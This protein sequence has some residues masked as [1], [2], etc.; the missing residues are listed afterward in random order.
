MEGK[1][2]PGI[3]QVTE[4]DTAALGNKT[5]VAYENLHKKINK[6][7]QDA[8]GNSLAKSDYGQTV[9]NKVSTS[10]SARSGIRANEAVNV[11]VVNIFVQT[12]KYDETSVSEIITK[13][14]GD[15]ASGIENYSKQDLCEYRGCKKNA[16]DDCSDGLQCECKDDLERPN[17]QVPFCLALVSNCPD[18][19]NEKNHKQCLQKDDGGVPECVCLPGY[20]DK[21]GTCEMCP[22][23]YSGIDCKDQFQLILTIVGS[24]AGILILSMVIAL[25]VLS[26][27]RNKPKNIEEQNLI[28]D[29]FS[30]L[31]LQETGFTNFGADGHIFPKIK[32]APSRDQP[33]NPY[34]NQRGW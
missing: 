1:I 23:G 27:S 11:L 16:G 22:F 26:R 10:S 29:S 18:N 3:V 31:K 12:T 30:S 17:L 14:L 32:I 21:E 8:F 28:E 6:F 13:A 2:F 5:S 20:Q 7:F 15:G 4:S 19:C 24:V 9:I 25:V 33:Q 34:V